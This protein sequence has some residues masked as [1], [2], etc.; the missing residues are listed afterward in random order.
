MPRDKKFPGTTDSRQYET[1][2]NPESL[3]SPRW[4]N[5]VEHG[6]KA[7]FASIL[8]LRKLHHK[9]VATNYDILAL[10]A[11]I[12]ALERANPDFLIRA[13]YVADQLNSRSDHYF[14]TPVSVGKMLSELAEAGELAY[15]ENTIPFAPIQRHT[16][17][18][19]NC[20]KI[21]D[22]AETY[23]WLFAL[24]TRAIDLA[25]ATMART[26]ADLLT[27]RL[28]QAILDLDTSEPA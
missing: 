17:R 9:Q 15:A 7:R 1:M 14:F 20:Y 11:V 2:S 12:D 4:R 25:N 13:P 5:Q 3:V 18:R 27:P 21:T 28:Q 19:G 8:A 24:R 6:K 22:E 23:R 26:A 10:L 16:D